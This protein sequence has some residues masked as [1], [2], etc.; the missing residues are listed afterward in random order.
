[1]KLF[2]QMSKKSVTEIVLYDQGVET[3]RIVIENAIN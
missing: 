2:P 3:L 1:M